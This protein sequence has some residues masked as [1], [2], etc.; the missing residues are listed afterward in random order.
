MEA[1]YHQIP[2]VVDSRSLTIVVP[3]IRTYKFTRTPLGIKSAPSAF[4]RIVTELV[5]DCVGTLVHLDDILIAAPD[6][7]ELG[8]RVKT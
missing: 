4:Q 3:H 7:I 5:G 8:K 2:L 1:A 6:R